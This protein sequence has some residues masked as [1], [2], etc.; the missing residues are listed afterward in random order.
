MD[1]PF[2]RVT[3]GHLVIVCF[4][5]DTLKQGEVYDT[6]AGARGGDKF[7]HIDSISPAKGNFQSIFSLIEAVV[8]YAERLNLTI[9]EIAI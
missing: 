1:A 4:W 5:N 6:H 7:E 3:I 2:A 8:W 9:D